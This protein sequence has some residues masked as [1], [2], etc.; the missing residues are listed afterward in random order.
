METFDCT[1]CQFEDYPNQL[2]KIWKVELDKPTSGCDAQRLLLHFTNSCN[3]QPPT[4]ISSDWAGLNV[5]STG[6]FLNDLNINLINSFQSP[7]GID[8]PV[9]NFPAS[10]YLSLV[11]ATNCT[12]STPGVGP[13]GPS[14]T[15]TITLNK[16]SNQ[17]QL[18]FNLLSDYEHYKDHF[19]L[20]ASTLSP[21][22]CSPS[23]TSVA[24]YR[25]FRL[26]VPIQAPNAN[27]GDNTSP[28]S[29]YFHVNDLFNIQYLASP[30]T[31]TW[32]IT[33]PQT[34]M[35]NCYPPNQSCDN[36]FN[37]INQWV[38]DYN[39]ELVIQPAYSYTTNTGAKYQQPALAAYI[40]RNAGSGPSGSYCIDFD[41]NNMWTMIS[42][43][44][45]SYYPWWS[46]NTIPFISS[47]NGWINLPNLGASLPC[48]T[49]SYPIGFSN[50]IFGW[51]QAGA[52]ASYSVR[53]PHLGGNGFD[54]SLSTNDF[55]IYAASGFGP[56]GSFNAN[57]VFNNSPN[58]Y[59][60]ACPPASQS[61]IYSYSASV[62]TMFTSSQFWQG[63]TPTLIIDL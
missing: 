10:G 3:F 44:E 37:L 48:N 59:S 56:T 4:S 31:N 21:T 49:G 26:N 33:I 34:L 42:Q 61:L 41:N 11:G 29:T 27:C 8:F 35:T 24:Y 54:Y 6:N 15:G 53:F 51:S 12:Y 14:S 5:G 22:T 25:Y 19:D 39:N 63:N 13:C 43:G 17:T 9:K 32:S 47:S 18:T 46:V 36:C 55:E 58:P 60:F 23:S 16:T 28:W 45:V 2:P 38:N 52:V 40:T 50:T 20:L 62:A 30:S 57:S 7:T 1:D